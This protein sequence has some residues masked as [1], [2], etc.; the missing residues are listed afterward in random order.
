MGDNNIYN[1]YDLNQVITFHNVGNNHV[2]LRSIWING[3][4]IGSRYRS[5]LLI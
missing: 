2:T 5:F 4:M 1:K 3:I